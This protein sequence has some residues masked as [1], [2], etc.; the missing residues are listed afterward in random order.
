MF[1]LVAG[2]G[3]ARR[4]AL[5]RRFAE[6]HAHNLYVWAVV[7]HDSRDTRAG[8]YFYG[9]IEDLANRS[10]RPKQATCRGSGIDFEACWPID[11]RCPGVREC[12]RVART[13]PR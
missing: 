8:A 7:W 5:S 11:P 9:V 10:T 13:R 4:R 3:R 1:D 6:T 2:A 12:A